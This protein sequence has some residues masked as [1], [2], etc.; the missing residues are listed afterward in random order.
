MSVCVNYVNDQFVY[1]VTFVFSITVLWGLK[2]TICVIVC[3]DVVHVSPGFTFS[4]ETI[5]SSE[6]LIHPSL[7]LV[8]FPPVILTYHGALAFAFFLFCPQSRLLLNNKFAGL[9]TFCAYL[10]LSFSSPFFSSSCHP[11]DKQGVSDTSLLSGISVNNN[12]LFWRPIVL[13]KTWG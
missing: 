11:K 1:Y 4:D 7:Q 13:T 10:F 2:Y 5:K 3:C 9:A 12:R 8:L 6:I